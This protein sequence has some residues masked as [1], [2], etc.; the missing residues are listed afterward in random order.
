MYVN[1]SRS[2]TNRNRMKW[3]TNIKTLTLKPIQQLKSHTAKP[4]IPQNFK[5]VQTKW[6]CICKQNCLTY[7]I[8]TNNATHTIILNHFRFPGMLK[9]NYRFNDSLVTSSQIE[10]TFAS[11]TNAI[12]RWSRLRN[13]VKI[14]KIRT[15]KR[16]AVITLKFEQDGFTE[17]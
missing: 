17:E 13:D 9:S 11:K 16:F 6:F 4:F 2:F 12:P 3:R 5:Y 14:L 7:D 10:M 15:S 1:Q 8:M